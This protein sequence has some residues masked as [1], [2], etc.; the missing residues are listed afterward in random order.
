VLTQLPSAH[1]NRPS[2]K[3]VSKEGKEVLKDG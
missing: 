3:G 1:G 2:Q